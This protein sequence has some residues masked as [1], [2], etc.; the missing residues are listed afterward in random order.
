M[1]FD[2]LVEESRQ[3]S[4]PL[5]VV[6]YIAKKALEASGTDSETLG[7]LARVMDAALEHLSADDK[8]LLAYVMDRRISET[9]FPGWVLFRSRL[10]TVEAHILSH[11][12]RD[13]GFDTRIRRDH[14]SAA[15]A[16]YASN[17][18]EIWIRPWHL[19]AARALVNDL[20]DASA[21]SI[22]CAACGEDNPAHFTSCWNC[23]QSLI[24]A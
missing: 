8:L 14:E 20:K 15:D 1:D 13:R 18:G 9:P 24:N 4:T 21:E 5:G 2:R 12:L 17:G 11:A 23:G 6:F 7:E 16:L 10:T 22:H 19:K 3:S